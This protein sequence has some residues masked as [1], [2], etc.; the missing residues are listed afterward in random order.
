MVKGQERADSRPR[1]HLW[2]HRRIVR[3]GS[4]L[5]R[6]PSRSG[7]SA[8]A[9]RSRADHA[10]CFDELDRGGHDN[11]RRRRLRCDG[12]GLSGSPS[13]SGQLFSGRGPVT[14]AS[15]S[16]SPPGERRR[17]DAERLVVGYPKGVSGG[18]YE[19]LRPGSV[20]DHLPQWNVAASGSGD[21]R[22]PVAC[23]WGV[24]ALLLPGT[25]PARVTVVIA[26]QQTVTHRFP[27]RRPFGRRQSSSNE[28]HARPSRLAGLHTLELQ[29]SSF[30]AGGPLTLDTPAGRSSPRTSYRCLRDQG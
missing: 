12:L 17:D 5:V 9:A 16:R 11:A 27:L 3:S 28:W 10:H 2:T 6:L 7:R 19:A 30:R 23:G 18:I 25:Q 15:V 13:L 4:S 26:R 21:Y 14:G 20:V 24:I 29:R 22:G 8:A 1:G